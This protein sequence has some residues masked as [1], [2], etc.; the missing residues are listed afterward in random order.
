MS[1]RKI[2]LILCLGIFLSAE[3][4]VNAQIVQ[5]F[6]YTGTFQTF[7]VPS[8]VTLITVNCSGGQGGGVNSDSGGRGARMIGAISVVP[9]EVLTVLVGKAGVGTSN[10]GS[11]GGGGGGSFVMH[12]ATPL[13]IA[14]GGGGR[15]DTGPAGN[16]PNTNGYKGQH[17]QNSYDNTGA[18]GAPGNG[19]TSGEPN[20]GGTGG[21]GGGLNT[22]GGPDGSAGG[23]PGLSYSNGATP[24]PGCTSGSDIGGAGGFGGGGGGTFCYRGTAGGG[25]GYSGGGTGVNDAG[26]GGGGSYEVAG[27]IDTINTTGGAA[28]GNGIVIFKYSTDSVGNGSTHVISEVTCTGGSNGKACAILTGGAY[29]TY[30]YSWSPGGQTR[31]TATGL[32]AGLYT[33]IVTGCGS[34]TTTVTITQPT[35]ICL[36]LMVRM[37]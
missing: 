2:I 14:G 18:G 1:Y 28:P 29:P 12:G 34:A 25:G 5:T 27:T 15:R 11:A 19:G 35:A 20:G 22:N 10:G 7:T 9:G 6:S 16:L 21:P 32:S 36:T 3:R 37:A 33:V 8:C 24:G 26:A 30:T 13:I 4:N 17:G 23:G 31:D